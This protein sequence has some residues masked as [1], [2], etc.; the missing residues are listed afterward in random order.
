MKPT[1]RKT[2]LGIGTLATG[3]GALFSSAA[4]ENSTTPSADL[5]VVVEEALSFRPNPDATDA[6]NVLDSDEFEDF[7]DGEDI[8]DS[9]T[10]AFDG[11]VEPPLAATNGEPNENLELFAVAG[12]GDTATFSE[13][14]LL[15]NDSTEA[16]AVGIGYDRNNSNFSTTDADAGQYGDDIDVNENGGLTPVIPRSSYRFEVNGFDGQG[17]L[18][19]SDFV[20]SQDDG[21]ENDA[22]YADTLISP[23]ENGD[24][25]GSEDNESNAE[26]VGQASSND[27]NDDTIT[28]LRDRPADA[29]ILEPGTSVTIDLVVDIDYS[30]GVQD[31]I[32]QAA[33]IS[34]DGFGSERATVDLLDGI[35]VGTLQ[36]YPSSS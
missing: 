31:N 3:S 15:E 21:D 28:D 5:R 10:G 22:D 36:N 13:L 18:T 8:D 32:R 7:F 23:A 9:D 34:L 24:V 16:V 30:D 2:V 12:L 6:D 11:D 26:F 35:T 25:S 4:F 17:N 14:F 27:G 29:I 19:Q 1:R 33:G 20:S